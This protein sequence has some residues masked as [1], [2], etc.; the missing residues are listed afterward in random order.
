MCLDRNL[1]ILEGLLLHGIEAE[2]HTLHAEIM[3]QFLFCFCYVSGLVI[4]AKHANKHFTLSI[5]LLE[6][7]LS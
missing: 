5:K 6:H 4:L 1:V 3:L 2:L 7:D